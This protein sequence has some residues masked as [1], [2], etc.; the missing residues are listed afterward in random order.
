MIEINIPDETEPLRFDTLADA[1]LEIRPNEL[2]VSVRE[3]QTNWTRAVYVDRKEEFETAWDAR[4]I[5]QLSEDY[6]TGFQGKR[7]DRGCDQ[8]CEEHLN[9]PRFIS[10]PKTVSLG[11]NVTQIIR[12]AAE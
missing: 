10:K 2:I 12:E 3:L 11:F 7:T 1:V 5:A 9:P 8:Y 6:W 4:R